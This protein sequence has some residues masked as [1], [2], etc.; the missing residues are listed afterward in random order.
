MLKPRRY[1]A[2]AAIFIAVLFVSAA[3]QAAPETVIAACPEAVKEASHSP[4]ET[5][6]V[7]DDGNP[8]LT[9]SGE[10]ADQAPAPAAVSSSPRRT[11]GID[12]KLDSMIH[13]I[14]EEHGVDAHLV[15]GIIK[16]ESGFNPKAK[17]R[18]GACGLMQLMPRTARK[19]GAKDIFDPADN[20][21]AGVKYFCYLLDMFGDVQKAL[22]AYLHGPAVVLK[23][24][25]VPQDRST[26]KFIE[27]ILRHS[28]TFSA[29]ASGDRPL[30]ADAASQVTAPQ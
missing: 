21:R 17:S 14:A 22:A 25:G 7:T 2:A 1:W 23:H 11:R 5:L 28:K 12:P 4:P 19:M 30:G 13:S 8:N 6:P 16:V 3:A 10:P 27:R 15:K 29:A 18:N 9:D 26:L 20:L 24:G